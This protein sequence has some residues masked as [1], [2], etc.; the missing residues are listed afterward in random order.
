MTTVIG[1]AVE[2]SDGVAKA[3]GEAVY[4]IDYA[5]PGMLHG[6]LLRSPVPAGRITALELEAALALPGVRGIFSAKDA[7]PC[8]A[9]WV[10][11]EQPLFAREVVRFEGEP[12][13][14]VVA[15]TI[16]IARQALRAIRLEI[17]PTQIVGDLESALL[18]ETPLV[19]PDWE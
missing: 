3:T 17:E 14:L 7:P 15:D 11:R 18:P 6:K 19:H 13:A 9:G 8:L 2:R 12:V 16:A 1:A 4:G 5:E 10:L